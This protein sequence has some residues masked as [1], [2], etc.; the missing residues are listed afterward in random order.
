MLQ[1]GVHRLKDRAK[2]MTLAGS[3][4]N[5]IRWPRAVSDV[6]SKKVRQHGTAADLRHL[7]PQ[8]DPS[9]QNPARAS[10]ARYS[11]AVLNHRFSER[12][13]KD[14]LR[15]SPPALPPTADADVT[16]IAGVIRDDILRPVAPE[17]P[18]Q[19]GEPID[20]FRRGSG[21]TPHLSF[22]ASPDR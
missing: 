4:R 12:G 3:G 21:P 2:E 11:P 1:G 14:S 10:R 13:E 20:R 15:T 19:A 5:E 6:R 22:C 9:T 18:D 17:S 16:L 8:A 7:G